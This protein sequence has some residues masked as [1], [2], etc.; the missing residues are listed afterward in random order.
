M[1]STNVRGLVALTV[2]AVLLPRSL[3]AAG[4]WDRNGFDADDLSALT[5]R[6]AALGAA[7]LRGEAELHA[8]ATQSAAATFKYVAQQA[9][10]NALV[11]RRYC[12][13]LSELDDRRAAIASCEVALR[14]HPSPPTLRA[15]VH[16][17]MLGTPT[18]EDLD[19][20][21]QLANAAQK[22]M[23]DQPWG[24]AA[25]S[26]IA[27]RTGDEK[28]LEMSV[29]E[30]ERIAP[31]HYE[32]SRARRALNGFHLS[33]WAWGAWGALGLAFVGTGAHA[34]WA[35][36]SRRRIRRRLST[37]A[38]AGVIACAMLGAQHASA[39]PDAAR[40]APSDA[41]EAAGLSKWPVNDA[42]PKKSLPTPEQ[43]DANPLEFGYH[44]MDLADK[45]DIAKRKGDIAA[46]AK[47]YEAMAVAV[48]DRAIG[49]RKS[50]DAYEQVGNA[51]KALQMC[52]GALAAEGV[53]LADYTHFSQLVLAKQGALAA[54][55]VDDLSAIATH[56]K[57]E[58]ATVA[59]GLQVQCQLAQRL[60]DVKRLGDCATDVAKETPNDPKLVIYQWGIAMKNEDYT[61][62][63]QLI[64]SARK[65]ALRPAGIEMMERMTQEQ[66]AFGRR[67]M[68]V[69]KRHALPVTVAFTVLLAFVAGAWARRR[70]RV[71][72][73]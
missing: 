14:L 5:R 4:A 26:D 23:D 12:E 25:K 11:A 66:S 71:R 22:H 51:E 27:E 37:V 8:G 53:E 68:R 15:A 73:A 30:L 3:H 31:G 28:M 7:F 35:G 46:V 32:T 58:P 10:D 38:G 63:Q 1:S 61:Q 29:L 48:P 45:A 40:P 17:L 42:D 69:L 39:A 57:A 13:T 21:A 65:S 36:V 18:P 52:R 43:R 56:L 49:Y 59:A 9:P 6:D 41:P 67:L 2:C 50:C 62:A 72:V 54:S 47:Y 64:E 55:D 33:G 44:M 34:A 24:L 19:V 16:A 70:F 20:A 60:D